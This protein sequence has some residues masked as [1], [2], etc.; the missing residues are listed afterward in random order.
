MSEEFKE[1]KVIRVDIDDEMK[2]AYLDYAMSVIVSRA[3]PDVRDGLKPVHRRILY[4]LY[5]LGMTPNKPHKKS[6]RIVGEVLGKYHP[7]GELAIYNSMVRMAQE[8]SYRYP[9]VDGHGNFGSIDGDSAAAMRYTEVRMSKI[10]T[11]LLHDIDQK[12]VDFVPNFDDS[13]KEPSI[14]PSRLPNLLMN[15][16][17]GIAVGMATSIPPHNVGEVID[18]VVALI[19]HPE[20]EIVNL[21]K[22]I[23][24][25]DFPTGCLIMG[26]NSIYKSYH[27][28]RGKLTV[29]A[30]TRIEESTSGKAKIIVDQIP[31]QVNKARLIEKIAELVRDE[32]ITGISD[33]RD[34]SDRRG[35][36]IMIEIKKGEVPQVIL[37]Q[38]YRYTQLQVTFSVIMLALVDGKPRVLNLKDILENY[39]NH[40]KEIVTR[41]TRHELE[42]AEARAHILEGYQIALANIDQIVELIK[43]SP[44]VTTAKNELIKNYSL[45]EKQAEAILRMRL[46][47]LTGLER[48]KIEAEHRELLEKI[49]YYRSILADKGKLLSI[50]KEELLELK[51]RYNDV[52]RTIILDKAVDLEV[53]DLIAEEQMVITLTHQGYIKRMH[54]DTYRSQKRGGKGIVGLNTKEEDFVEDIFITST[55][56]YFLFFTNRGKVYRL[57]VF[58]IPEAG[59]QARGTAIVNLLQLAEGER[60]TTVIPIREFDDKKFLVM[61]TRK[62][63]I[64]KTPLIEYKSHYTGLIGITL[65][66]DDDLID[67]KYTDGQQEIIIATHKGQAIHFKEQDVRKTGRVSIGVKAMTLKQDDYVIGM[68]VSSEGQDLL[69]I[70]KNGYG[71][72]TPLDEY[73]LQTRGGKGLIT[74]NITEKNGYLA[75]IKVVSDEHE[76]IIITSD[77][78]IIR[79][80]VSGISRTGRNTQGVRVIRLAEGDRVVALARITPEIDQGVDINQNNIID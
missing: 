31:Y 19:D 29:R 78:I 10:T 59:R 53:E 56:H 79:T 35:L 48:D 25:P 46:Q 38:L 49:N 6:A 14:L 55:H 34:E 2:G 64:K 74:A 24:G 52:R 70:T 62:G 57:R 54:V 28:G 40:Q 37:N 50:I 18:S 20:L 7:H 8:F 67:V 80:E 12:T 23:K 76:L 58:E 44:D 30:K 66:E 63:L 13:L 22:I 47:N 60:V 1:G 42:K 61:V 26:R 51:K 11:D 15:G 5:D 33:L 71:K 68:G 72:R 41:R 45:S 4:S 36:R 75:G 69:V 77:G 43:R 16:S 65:R 17:S 32:K 39:L 27:T 9:L 73:R 21:M 3:L